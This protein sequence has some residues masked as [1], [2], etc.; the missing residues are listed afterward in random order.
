MFSSWGSTESTVPG[1]QS[2]VSESETLG[3][4]ESGLSSILCQGLPRAAPES[5]ELV[6]FA[7]EKTALW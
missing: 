3:R 7:V 6:A 5:G 4:T 2:D 1:D